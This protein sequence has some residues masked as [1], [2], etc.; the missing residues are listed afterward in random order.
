MA[1]LTEEQTLIRDQAKSWVSE[2]F[3]VG[4][5]RAL[6]D[7]GGELGYS[8]EAWSAMVEM[9]WTGILVPEAHGGSNLGYLTFGVILEELGRQLTASPLLVSA[10]AGASAVLLGG[11]DAQKDAWLPK[12]VDGSEIL[13]LAV[14]EGPRHMPE[15]TALEARRSGSGFVLN[16][17]KHFV[18][19]GM[20]ATAFVVAA[21][22]SGAPGD[23]HG[24]S[25]FLDPASSDGITR[26]SLKT[27]DSRG[28]ADLSLDSV[29]VAES[30]LLGTV[31]GGFPL[32][33][34]ILD[35]AR[36]GLAAEML[37]TS[38]RAFDMTLEYLKTREQFGQV[39]GSFQALGH[40]AAGLYSGMELARS[41]AEAALQ[42]IDAGADN[43]A[44]LSSLA[45]CKVGDH[46]HL[47]SN[48]MIQMHGGIGMTDEFDAGL[49][50][51]RARALE[52]TYGNQ[53]FHR[54]RYARLLGY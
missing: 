5:F 3:P 49:Y 52:A 11:S 13:T 16:G 40:R 7:A 48:E 30:A 20:A 43:V 19:E 21:R 39:I 12:I 10:L 1:A 38:A 50:L 18:L 42:A 45:K 14:D 51:K 25:L 8:P 6:R 35:R 54:E 17:S 31:D 2:Q 46:L 36:A 9:G 26:T 41:C 34:A 33:D 44:E 29:S 22:S 4:K 53:G 15:K 28:Y 27:V 37:G 23:S 47:M 32:L 24:I